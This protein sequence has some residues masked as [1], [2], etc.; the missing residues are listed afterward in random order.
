[1][2]TRGR[3]PVPN[4]LKILRGTRAD[5]I[6]TDAPK[7]VQGLPE[8]PSH[9]DLVARQEW[10]RIVPLLDQLGVLTR[11]DGA[12]LGLYCMT[13]SRWCLA[14]D[15][16]QKDGLTVFTDKGS[17]KGN[18]AVA[19][20]TQAEAQMHRLLVEFGCTP[21]SRGRLKTASAD[22]PKDE[23]AAFISKRKA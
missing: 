5:R 15:S 4:E 13:F 16:I 12:A 7:G 22:G 9:L 6:N 14:Q 10:D 11:T 2:A 8:A 3:K 18:P 17:P 19:I 20:A 21:S 1:M 23:L